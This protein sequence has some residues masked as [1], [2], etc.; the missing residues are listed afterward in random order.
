MVKKCK[1]EA[2]MSF[3][4]A[5]LFVIVL[6][7]AINVI[8]LYLND[9]YNSKKEGEIAGPKVK[10]AM[11]YHGINFIIANEVTNES[12]FFRDG[13]KCTLFTVAF[14]ERWKKLNSN[15]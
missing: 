13:Q 9:Y 1:A 2:L 6:Y 7:I 8:P 12:W 15:P 10:A 11:R 3:I 14:E 4:L 5:V